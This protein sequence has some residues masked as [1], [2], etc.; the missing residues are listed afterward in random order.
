MFAQEFECITDIFNSFGTMDRIIVRKR[1]FSD[2]TK[3]TVLVSQFF[4]FEMQY[5]AL[6]CKPDFANFFFSKR[7]NAF[8]MQDVAGKREAHSYPTVFN[9]KISNPRLLFYIN[10]RRHSVV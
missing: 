5:S 3:K 7:Y 2:Q 9:V 4:N 8:E 1:R 10:R 6:T